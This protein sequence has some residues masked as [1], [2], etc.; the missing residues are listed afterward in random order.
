MGVCDNGCEVFVRIADLRN[1]TFGEWP[2]NHL[3][4]E[5]TPT[6]M[7]ETNAEGSNVGLSAGSG[8]ERDPGWYWVRK[9]DLDG[10]YGDWTPALW[11]ADRRAWYTWEF[12]GVPDSQMIVGERLRAPNGL[13]RVEIKS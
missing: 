11:K 5:L 9:E 2:I 6:E 8:A 12:S 4:L 1:K 10:K 7:T 13:D 3:D